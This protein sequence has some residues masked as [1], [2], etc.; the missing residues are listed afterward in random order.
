VSEPTV[1]TSVDVFSDGS[2]FFV[3]TEI[4]ARLVK[5]H[6]PVADLETAKRE[7]QSQLAR[8]QASTEALKRELQRATSGQ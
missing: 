7:Q 6:G 8:L 5:V 3:R 4:E 2:G 1:Q